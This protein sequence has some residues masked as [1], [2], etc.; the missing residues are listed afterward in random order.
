MTFSAVPRNTPNPP[1]LPTKLLAF[2]VPLSGVAWSRFQTLLLLDAG[3]TPTAIGFFKSCSYLSKIIFAPFWGVVGDLYTPIVALAL[4]YCL[5]GLS[6]ELLR[7]CLLRQWSFTTMLLIKTFRSASNCIGAVTEAVLYDATRHR[8]DGESF[9]RQRLLSSLAW[10]VGSLC[11]GYMIDALGLWSIFPYTY[12]MISVAL[13]LLYNLSLYGVKKTTRTVVVSLTLP[14]TSTPSTKA[15]DQRSA[16]NTTTLAHV[17]HGL[18]QLFG[19]PEL[20]RTAVQIIVT[21][22][23][24]TLVDQILPIQLD[25]EYHV[26]RWVNGMTTFLSIVSSLPVYYY[27]QHIIQQQGV[28]WMF[29]TGQITFAI[30][31]VGMVVFSMSNPGAVGRGGQVVL[32]SCLQLLHGITFALV[33]TGATHQLQNM[34]SPKQQM[35]TSASTLVS[36]LYFT[37]GQGVGNVWW[38]YLYQKYHNCAALYG[39]GFGLIAVN[40]WYTNRRGVGGHGNNGGNH[41][42][43]TA[44]YKTGVV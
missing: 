13:V 8:T 11:A 28:Y 27:S 24:M 36:T 19:H 3:Y 44:H 18:Q 40:V 39:L 12:V 14:T 25:Q 26:P 15:S 31:L 30:R 17:M 29:Q 34:S 1:L 16:L 35:T 7:Q 2:C 43:E 38:L 33:W 5:S 6:L 10:G 41:G 9:G 20:S 37:I 22:F 23:L 4:S 32:L 21:G 42:G